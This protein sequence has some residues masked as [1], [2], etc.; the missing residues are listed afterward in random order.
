MS[1]AKRIIDL[2][3]SNVTDFRSAFDRD[4]LR[5]LLSSRKEAAEARAEAEAEAEAEASQE[6]GD[7]GPCVGDRAGRSARKFR[8]AGVVAW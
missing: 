6:T 5:D 8:D 3:R 2:A 1:I 4:H 7:D